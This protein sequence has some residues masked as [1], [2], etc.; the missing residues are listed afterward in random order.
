MTGLWID[1]EK[2]PG[3]DQFGDAVVSFRLN[4]QGGRKFCDISRKNVGKPFAIVLDDEVISA[5]VIREAI[6]GGRGQISGGFDVQA[7]NDLALLL[8]AGAL[9]APRAEGAP[10]PPKRAVTRPLSEAVFP[11]KFSLARPVGRRR[12]RR[13][14]YSSHHFDFPRLHL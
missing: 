2:L 9:P 1:L 11:P 5:P 12:R 4:S 7:A 3:F 8:R 6:C 13:H 10:R 14:R